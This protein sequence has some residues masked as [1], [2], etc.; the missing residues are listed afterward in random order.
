MLD[1]DVS[2]APEG[3]RESLDPGGRGV[4]EPLDGVRV[5]GTK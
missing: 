4:L 1:T 5:L 2:D 3:F